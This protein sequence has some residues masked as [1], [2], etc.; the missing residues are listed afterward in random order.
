ME[1]SLATIRPGETVRIRTIL[2]DLVREECSRLGV[3]AG[4]VVRTILGS[5]GY[6]LLELPRGARVA[7]KREWTRFIDTEPGGGEEGR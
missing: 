2:F 6:L 1:S 4:Q 5:D 7:L 3:H